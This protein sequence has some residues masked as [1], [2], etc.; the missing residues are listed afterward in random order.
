LALR[1]AAAKPQARLNAKRYEGDRDIAPGLKPT[2]L[3][4]SLLCCICSG[5]KQGGESHRPDSRPC[6]LVMKIISMLGILLWGNVFMVLSRHRGIT[7]TIR[8]IGRAC[9]LL[10]MTKKNLGA[11][12]DRIDFLL[13]RFPFL[14][15][16][17]KQRCLMRGLLLYF[18][19]KR[20]RMD[21][22]LQFGSKASEDGFDTHCW[23]TLKQKVQFEVE[24]EVNQYTLLV[25]YF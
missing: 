6:E 23:V 17:R 20:R 2:H 1:P 22:R 15:M 4:R 19:G 12:S 9:N 18:H 11:Y 10:P 16:G 21:I 13:E 8:F 24:D 14:F 5:I 3:S 7:A 25:E